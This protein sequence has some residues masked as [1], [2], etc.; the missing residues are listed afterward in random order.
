MFFV[1]ASLLFP[2][3]SVFHCQYINRVWYI[4]TRW[5]HE[6]K[7]MFLWDAVGSGS[8]FNGSNHYWIL[9]LI[10]VLANFKVRIIMEI[11]DTDY[12]EDLRSIPCCII[13]GSS[14]CMK[15][16][17]VVFEETVLPD[18]FPERHRPSHQ[19]KC[20]LQTEQLQSCNRERKKNVFSL[21]NSRHF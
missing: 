16:Y 12:V 2:A 8:L 17:I 11:S 21:L 19:A 20:L 15:L 9:A 7:M 6:S 5:L 18:G 4:Y 13:S 14:W 10:E 3:L 1:L